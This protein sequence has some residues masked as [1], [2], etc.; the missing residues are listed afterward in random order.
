M[1]EWQAIKVHMYAK[2]LRYLPEKTY[3]H[4]TPQLKVVIIEV[5]IVHVIRGELIYSAKHYKLDLWWF[6]S[7][8]TIFNMKEVVVF[9]DTVR[10][11]IVAVKN[12]WR[13][14]IAMY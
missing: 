12:S 3:W 11:E 1:N 7:G 2:A 8:Q 13:C 9:V 4:L 14:V 5:S 6:Y 10:W